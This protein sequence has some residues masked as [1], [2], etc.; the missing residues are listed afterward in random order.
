MRGFAQGYGIEIFLRTALP[1][2]ICS[3]KYAG[4]QENIYA[5][6]VFSSELST[7][8]HS[9]VFIVSPRD[10]SSGFVGSEMNEERYSMFDA[11]ALN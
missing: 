8:L 11:K 10:F 6:C 3:P 7:R 9:Y 5:S 4:R 1:L 2:L